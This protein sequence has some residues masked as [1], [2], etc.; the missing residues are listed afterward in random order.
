[1][2]VDGDEGHQPVGGIV[3]GSQ[4]LGCMK[5]D[6]SEIM[7]ELCRNYAAATGKNTQCVVITGKAETVYCTIPCR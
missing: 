4:G 5:L 1:M 3:Q 6:R 7:P 2:I